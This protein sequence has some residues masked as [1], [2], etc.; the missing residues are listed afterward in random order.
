MELLR[1]KP[2]E[3][4]KKRRWLLLA[5]SFLTA[6]VIATVAIPPVRWRIH[7]VALKAT[8][9]IQDLSWR[10][11]V[12]SMVHRGSTFNATYLLKT[13]DP[14]SAIFAP[15]P[16]PASI[17]AG[18]ELFNQQCAPCHG[19]DAK[20]GFAP[21]LTKGNFS[22]GATDWAL[23]RT[24]TDGIVGTPM[25]ARDLPAERVWQL[26]SFIK[27]SRNA[28]TLNKGINGASSPGLSLGIDPT[29]EH[30]KA[31]A[32]NP[33]DWLTYSATYSAQRHSR[34]S[35]ITRDNVARLRLKWLY[36][37]AQ[38][39]RGGTECTP[40]VVGRYM[41]VTLPPGDVWALD[42]RTGEKLWSYSY[43]VSTP[44][45]NTPVHNRGVAILGNTIYLGTLN[46]HLLA[47]DA[48]TGRLLWDVAVADNQDGYGI[49][50]APLALGDK[51]VVG[52]S[53]GDFGIRGFVDAYSPV[54]GKRLWRFYTVPGPGEP[55]HETWGQGDSWK[56][57]GGSTWLTGSYDSD[58]DL[59]Y[60][61]VG[62]PGPDYQGDVRPG[63]NLYTCSVIAIEAATGHL[64]WHYQFSPHD[65]HDWDSTQIPVLADAIFQ[66][67]PRKLMYFAN[68]NGFFYILDR[69]NGKFLAA[70]AFAKQTWAS[71]FDS[72]GVP[73][74]RPEG[75]PTVGGS[76]IYPNSQGATNWWSPS[77]DAASNTMYVPTMEGSDVYKKGPA[78]TMD[79]GNYLGGSATFGPTWTAVRALDAATGRLRWEY[80]FP[81]R[82]PSIVMG[83][84][85]STGGGVVF[86][87]DDSLMVALDAGQG[88][89][90]WHFNTGAGIAAAPITYLVDGRQQVTLV[91][92]MTVLTFSLDAK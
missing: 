73:I 15:A 35:Q 22:H 3:R 82:E 8:G 52:V 86:G 6:A 88:K 61:G 19:E 69:T 37:F 30:L 58:L 64:R 39:T 21:N 45:K 32:D 79:Y 13:K 68:R 43:P 55:G 46:A 25:Q 38:F 42:T 47:L 27:D 62:N 87:G 78:V 16:T 76:I 50:S 10:E 5:V 7:L 72:A 66:G 74:Q 31:A 12:H 36:Q 29:F 17:R 18:R 9:Q 14:Y 28:T 11:M 34:L 53:G 33:A 49:T 26:V 51:I 41:F 63:I 44:V 85:L 92:G 60:W 54:D 1:G 56:R 84:L 80:R 75:H 81:P 89:E 23:Y 91:S 83:G 77:Y 65:E 24:I 67:Q 48:A 40:L 57:G 2:K 90:L 20:G 59:I 71:G 70:E 4:M